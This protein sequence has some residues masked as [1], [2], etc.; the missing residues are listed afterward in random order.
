[1][2]Q[3]IPEEDIFNCIPTDLSIRAAY[4]YAKEKLG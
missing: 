4:L 2:A 1:M 3:V